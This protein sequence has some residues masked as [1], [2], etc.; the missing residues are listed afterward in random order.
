[1]FD[2]QKLQKVTKMCFSIMLTDE[3]AFSVDGV[4]QNLKVSFYVQ[5]GIMCLCVCL[6]VYRHTV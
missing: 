1:M 6:F 2:A 4:I 3:K 5:H